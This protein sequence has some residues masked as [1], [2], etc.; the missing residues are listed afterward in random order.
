MRDDIELTI[1]MP[2]LN[3][4]QTIGI[5]IKKA[6][7]FLE[8]KNIKGEILISDNGST[9]RS[10]EIANYLGAKVVNENIKG[11]GNALKKGAKEAKGKYVIMGDCDDSYDFF[12]LEQFV[13]KLRNGYDLVIGNRFKGGIQK[14]A[15]PFSHKI[16]NPLISKAGRIIYKTNV[17]DWYCGL[18]GYNK[19]SILDLNLQ[20]SGMEYA[21]E[22]IIKSVKNKYK[23]IE[24]PTTLKK[25]GRNRPP[26]LNTVKDGIRTFKCLIKNMT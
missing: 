3:E 19:K 15:M 25:D 9:D 5:C 11:Y 7:R 26:H 22:M 13:E 12:Y 16:G 8:E 1:L 4:E 20:S 14:G 10:I 23:I 21:I 2:C 24:I 17:G 18:R 6:K